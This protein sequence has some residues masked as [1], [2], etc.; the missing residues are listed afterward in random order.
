[1]PARAT[2]R[3]LTSAQLRTTLL[4]R[5]GLLERAPAG[6]PIPDVI[7]AMGGIQDQYAPSGYVGLWTRLAGFERAHL[8]QALEDRSVI[9]ATT[10]RVT[11]HLHSARA[12][13]PVAMGVREARRTWWLRLQKG[14]VAEADVAAK[15]GWL[16]SALADGPRDTKDLGKEAAGFIG[17]QGLWVDLVRVP[18][19][20]TWE[21]RRADR[22]AL[23]EAWVGPPD[24]T[25]SEGR[26]YLV[27]AYL[28]A[29]GPAPW[30]DIAIWAGVPSTWLQ[31]AATDLAL[32]RYT[33]ERERELVDL[34]G[35]AIADPDAPVPVRFVAHWDALLL[36]HARRTQVLPE[37]HRTRIFSDRNPFS[38][39][40]VLV[41]GQGAAT[42]SARDGDVV[43]EPLRDLPA[44]ERDAVEAERADLEAFHR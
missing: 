29:F 18:P 41:G 37:E 6:T 36:V 9:Q 24:T 30:G 11:I 21:R 2:H 35:M 27:E 16:R 40:C 4:H 28:R 13:W 39:G 44:A 1:M 43:V 38:V 19:S 10:L 32:D 23:A 7:D 25:E 42:W 33:D 8:T 15:A 12:F 22:L 31:E 34:P 20:G 3:R 14:A 17:N 5:Q 26:R